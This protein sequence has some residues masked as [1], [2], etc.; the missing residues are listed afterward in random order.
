M[1]INIIAEIGTSHGGDLKR[2]IN[3]IDKAEEAGA[4]AVK[5][6]WVYADEILHPATG[7]VKLPSGDTPLYSVFKSLEVPPA[8]FQTCLEHARSKHLKFACSPFGI[9]SLRQLFALKPDFI[10]IASPELNHIPLLK[11]L[12]L[13]RKQTPLP[14]ILSSGVS[15][16]ADIEKALSLIGTQG[17]T[18][19][20]CVTAY[21]APETD[22]NLK[23]LQSL[24]SIFGV[25]TGV[26]DHSPDPVLVPALSAACGAVAIEKHITAANT[27]GGLDDLIALTPERFFQMSRSVR[28]CEALINRLGKEQGS[29][30]IIKQ[31]SDQYGEE[32]VRAVLGDGVKRLA[33]SEHENYGR[34]NRSLHYVRSLKSG[35]IVRQDDIA[36]LRTEKNLTPGISS[37][38]QEN[39][40]GARLTADVQSGEGVRLEHFLTITP[41]T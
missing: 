12:A 1:N 17:V 34:T 24:S 27:A 32:K 31:M 20:H 11:E 14:V 10:K 4:S 2:A 6:Q 26:S 23:L 33:Q 25:N 29:A 36:V 40:I 28:Q 7:L 8:F 30:Q 39:I 35:Q 37:A 21:P 16:L 15:L 5:F 38:A 18:L 3:L 41:A 22:Y 19:L 9:K 13:L